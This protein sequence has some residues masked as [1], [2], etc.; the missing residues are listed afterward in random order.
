MKICLFKP[1]SNVFFSK[2]GGWCSDINEARLFRMVTSALAFRE[3]EQLTDARLYLSCPSGKKT[4][5]LEGTS[6]R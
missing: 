1:C 5:V 4:V 6:I 2:D 3:H